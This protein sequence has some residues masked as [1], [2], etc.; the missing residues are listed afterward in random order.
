M[1]QN[2][3]NDHFVRSKFQPEEIESIILCVHEKK[4]WMKIY[5]Q[6]EEKES[7][8]SLCVWTKQMNEEFLFLN[9][10]KYFNFSITIVTAE[11]PSINK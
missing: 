9:L 10:K 4:E 2:K 8:E 5:C 6:E 7:I 11:S 1:Y 3:T